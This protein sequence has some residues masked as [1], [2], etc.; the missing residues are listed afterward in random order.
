MKQLSKKGATQA[1][2]AFRILRA[3]FNF[4]REEYRGSN[5]E[6]IIT[7]NPVLA[8]KD[9]W[10]PNKAKK[11][12]I[13]REHVGAVWNML[14]DKRT[15]PTSVT[16]AKT[17]ADIVVFLLLTGC[18]WSEAADLTWD[19]VDL[20]EKTWF[21]PD[22]K[23]H[24]PILFPLSAPLCDMLEKRREKN[25]KGY[26]F[27]SRLKNAIGRINNARPTMI[28][29]SEKSKMHITPHDLRR[30]FIAIGLSKKVELWKLKLLTN[31]IA[32]GDVIINNYTEKYDL[33]YLSDITG[34]IAEWVVEQGRI[35]AAVAA[36][37]NNILLH[38]AA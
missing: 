28:A 18:R 6:E 13:P 19:R 27:Q 23:N 1:N 11:G 31:H 34:E 38:I 20:I 7:S 36:S 15:S 21:I 10:N 3:L 35:S 26:V 22:P 25:D 32:E 14:Q 9:K 29:L 37:E 4:A 12:R 24:N 17:G 2:Q 16:A 5:D 30:T 33:R 8:L